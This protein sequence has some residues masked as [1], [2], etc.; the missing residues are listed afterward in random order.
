M[1]FR[2]TSSVISDLLLRLRGSLRFQGGDRLAA[3]WFM[4]ACAC[5]PKAV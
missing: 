1:L 5:G 4:Y 2:G 3:A